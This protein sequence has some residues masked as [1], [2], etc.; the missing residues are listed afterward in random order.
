MTWIG[1]R[2]NG[3]ETPRKGNTSRMGSQF[4]GQDSGLRFSQVVQVTAR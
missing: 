2:V 3:G 1:D 4:E